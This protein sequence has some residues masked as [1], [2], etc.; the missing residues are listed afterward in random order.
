MAQ[1]F[2]KATKYDVKSEM[3]TYKQGILCVCIRCVCLKNSG[4]ADV[5]SVWICNVAVLTAKALSCESEEIWIFAS[6]ERS[7]LFRHHRRAF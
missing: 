2:L 5:L 3:Q 6:P 1:E 7:R 4:G